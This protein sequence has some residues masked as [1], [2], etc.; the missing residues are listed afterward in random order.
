MGLEKLV[1][2]GGVDVGGHDME[3]DCLRFGDACD[4]GE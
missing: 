3:V 4:V 2:E 1:E